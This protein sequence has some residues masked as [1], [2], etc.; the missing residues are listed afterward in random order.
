MLR[1]QVAF[2]RGDVETAIPH[3]E[4]ATKLLPVGQ[5]GAVAARAMLALACM[6]PG[7]LPRFSELS[8]ELDQLSPITP[9]D[10]LFQGLLETTIRPERGLQTLDEGIRRVDSVVARATRL[11]ARANRALVNGEVGLA[12]LAVDDARVARGMLPGNALVLAR[13]VFAHL[14]LAGI[15][16]AAGRAKDSQRVLAEA[17]PLVQELE[18]FSATP[19]TAQACFEYFEYVG[20]EE[21]AYAMSGRGSQL[22]RAVMLY[23]R[24]EIAKALDAA[25]ECSRT[26]TLGPTERL[27]RALIVAELPDGFAR[28]LTTFEEVKADGGWQLTPP[29]I[30]LFLGKTEEARQAFLQVPQEELPPWDDGWYVKFLDYNCGRITADVLLQAAGQSR[31]KV[32]DARFMIGLWRLSEGDRFAARDHFE[33]SVATRVFNSWE[34]PW[35]RAFLARMEQDRAWP[36]WI[37][38]KN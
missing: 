11:E 31:P 20:D 18:P 21:A 10:F 34:W 6:N 9:E 28:A 37:P 15:Y 33:K 8:Q 14:V 2:H 16:E 24:G 5:P 12:E 17:R 35:V 1:G 26:R 36:P 25:T 30:L 3:L 27:E 29:M 19:F 32:S 38:L 23:R 13:S 4:Q 7:L 22:R